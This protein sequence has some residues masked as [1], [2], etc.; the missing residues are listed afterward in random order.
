MNANSTIIIGGG[1]AGLTAAMYLARAGQSCIILESKFWGGQTS[2]LNKV[3]NYPG[4]KTTS[5]FDISQSLYEQV[6]ELNVEMKKENV[7]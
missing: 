2:L 1:V 3:E 7:S 4:I 6:K 5:G